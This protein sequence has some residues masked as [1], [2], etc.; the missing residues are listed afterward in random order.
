MVSEISCGG[1]PCNYVPT[2]C[3]AVIIQAA[4]EGIVW[5]NVKSGRWQD[6]VERMRENDQTNDTAP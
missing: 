1:T 6:F 3:F 5:F 2:G 4:G